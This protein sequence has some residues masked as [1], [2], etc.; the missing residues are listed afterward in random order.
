MKRKMCNTGFVH[1]NIND[2]YMLDNKIKILTSLQLVRKFFN[3]EVDKIMI[4]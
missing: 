1:V 3:F 4:K 2:W